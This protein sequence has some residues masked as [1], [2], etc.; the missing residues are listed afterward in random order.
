MEPPTTRSVARQQQLEEQVASILAL[1]QE[2]GRSLAEQAQH[3]ERRQT[4]LMHDCKSSTGSRWQGW[5]RNTSIA[6]ILWIQ[7]RQ[8]RLRLKQL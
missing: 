5:L 7:H 4:Q 8:R 2:Q 1:M 3:S 6:G